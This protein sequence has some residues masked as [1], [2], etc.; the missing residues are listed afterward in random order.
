MVN[1]T[2]E[3]LKQKVKEAI[4]KYGLAKSDGFSVC[5]RAF[6]NEPKLFLRAIDMIQRI[7]GKRPSG[8]Y[9]VGYVLDHMKSEKEAEKTID[10]LAHKHNLP[11][12]DIFYTWE[13]RD[14]FYNALSKMEQEGGMI[15][16]GTVLKRMRAE[17]IRQNRER[18][19]RW[20]EYNA[21]AARKRLEQKEIISAKKRQAAETLAKYSH[22]IGPI[23]LLVDEIEAAKR[24]R[25]KLR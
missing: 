25:K 9:N 14:L 11:K 4:Q 3:E 1:E 17:K 13:G 15:N 8:C 21:Q 24:K 18:S 2:P 6:Y 16:E 23:D 10:K 19:E 7:H 20:K 12:R 22:V 5:W